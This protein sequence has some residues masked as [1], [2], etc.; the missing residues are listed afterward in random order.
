MKKLVL[1]FV[2]ILCSVSII[3]N[4]QTTVSVALDGNKYNVTVGD[5]TIT[6]ITA[7]T[8]G[9]VNVLAVNRDGVKLL[10]R[11]TDV[12]TL[13]A[14]GTLNGA[15]FHYATATAA[16]YAAQF[17]IPNSDFETWTSATTEPKN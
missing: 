3:A 8:Q 9:D 10:V 11:F 13:V 1:L 14:D 4:A 15:D 6:G 17:Q 5:N 2:T 12:N 7:I 16:T